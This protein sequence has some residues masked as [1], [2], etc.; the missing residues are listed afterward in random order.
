MS[1]F[2]KFLTPGK[3]VDDDLELKLKSTEDAIPVKN[4]VPVYH[5]EMVNKN[6]G[7]KMGQI[8]LRVGF[9]ENIKYGGNIGYTVDEKFR[10][11]KYAARAVKLLLPFAKKHGLNEVFITCNPENAPSR[12]TI[13]IAGGQFV[14]VSD[15]PPDNDEYK[16]GHKQK[17]RYRL[18]I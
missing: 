5:F 7:E 2:F 17:S 3:L 1:E 9:N 15:L 6:T 4:Y 8:D 13:E 10:G 16:L 18:E 14:E 12:R 11:H